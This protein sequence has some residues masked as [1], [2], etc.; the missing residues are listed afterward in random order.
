VASGAW[1]PSRVLEAGT[2]GARA[3]RSGRGRGGGGGA[4][5]G[6]GALPGQIKECGTLEG[7][8]CGG[9]SV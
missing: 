4:A 5:K 3:G 8:G 6:E 9:G 2:H 7:G 1:S